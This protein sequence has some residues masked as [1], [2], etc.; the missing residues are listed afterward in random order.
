MYVKFFIY[1]HQGFYVYTK[2]PFPLEETSKSYIRKSQKIYMF[3]PKVL[4]LSIKTFNISVSLPLI[5]NSSNV[6]KSKN[7]ILEK[8]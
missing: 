6:S 4:Y 7:P 1:G 3:R 2:E 5:F 8:K